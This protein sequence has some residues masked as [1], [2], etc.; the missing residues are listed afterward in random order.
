MNFENM[1]PELIEKIKA[2]KTEEELF[3]LA[4]Q[5]GFELTEDELNGIAGG[6]VGGCLKLTD[7]CVVLQPCLDKDIYVPC[8]VNR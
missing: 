6:L 4:K 5:E 3:E 1:A 2:C 8:I 7:G